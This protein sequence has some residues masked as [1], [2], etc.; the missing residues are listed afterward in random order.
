MW[1]R[2]SPGPN[3]SEWAEGV[4]KLIADLE[5]RVNEL[6]A[7]QENMKQREFERGHHEAMRELAKQAPN[8]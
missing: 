5:K 4:L 1:T 7:E 3:M 8:G 6:E 2:N